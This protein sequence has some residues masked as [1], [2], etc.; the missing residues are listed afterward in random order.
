M[1]QSKGDRFA[2]EA[3]LSFELF[4]DLDRSPDGRSLVYELRRIDAGHGVSTL[5]PISADGGAPRQITFGVDDRGPRR[6]RDGRRATPVSGRAGCPS[7]L[8][9]SRVGAGELLAIDNG[10]LRKAVTLAWP[11]PAG[12]ATGATTAADRRLAHEPQ[13]GSHSGRLNWRRARGCVKGESVNERRP[14]KGRLGAELTPHGVVFR[15]WSTRARAVAVA[16]LD[17]TGAHAEREV[18]LEA[19]GEGH[20]EAT[21]PGL[22]PG[23][24]YK[25]LLDG[26]PLPDPYARRLP[27]GV[28]GPAE[29]VDPRA[30]AWAHP[31]LRAPLSGRTVIYELHVG[32]FTPEGTF[33]AARAR[34]ADLAALGVSVVELMPLSSFAGRRGWGYDGVAHFAPHAAYGT[35]DE[36]KALVDEA[37]G[38]GLSVWLDV[39]YNHFG[40]EGNYLG[41][42]SPAYFT[43][44]TP[45]PWGDGPDYAEPHMRRLLVDNALY[46]L[47]EFRLD[48][49]R[50]DATHH[51]HDPSPKHVL[52]ELAEAARSLG[53]PP[54]VLVAEDDRNDPTLVTGQGLDGLWA[55]DFHHALHVLLTG[56][57]DGYYAGYEAG[58][59][60][61]ARAIERGWLYEGQ[62]WP[63]TGRPR[64][65]SAAGLGASRFVYALQNH[66]QVGNRARGE[67]LHHLVSPA[68]WRAASTLLLFLPMTPLLFMGQEWAASSPFLYFTDFPEALGRQVSEGRRREFEGF[69]AFAGGGGGEVPDPQA[70]DTFA[71]SVLDW[72]ER[73]A[74]VHRETLALYAELLRLRRH[75]PVLGDA[76]RG[77]LRAGV[78]GGLLWAWRWGEGGGHRALVWN[79]TPDPVPLASLPLPEG[80]AWS[81][82]ACSEGAG[83]R[84]ALGPFVA[85]VFAAEGPP[86]ESA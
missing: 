19:R 11:R 68:A 62:P 20:F 48:G 85:A 60:E 43:A 18:A 13:R 64:G 30:Y 82:L 35:P 80:Y 78:E 16:L 1:G 40:P 10:G 84:E 54:P 59:G 72:G 65:A 9:T 32:T 70:E 56:E 7:Q 22:G 86:P 23:A 25:F 52:A 61:L 77:R 55:D 33:A 74:A 71:A 76:S 34:L 66:D 6:S 45:T 47:D 75:D 42:Y 26:E 63:L 49:L 27:F 83:P 29:V 69:A 8:S 46:W 50:L 57:R 3:L 38:L 36:L 51:I 5:W 2:P 41:A 4:A 17:R 67:R 12:R 53:G 31:P 44:R 24:L 21:V 73:D 15:A 37:H 14:G 58:A 81:P 39:V 79:V 28:H